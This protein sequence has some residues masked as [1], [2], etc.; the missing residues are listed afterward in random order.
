M[1]LKNLLHKICGAGCVALVAS[2]LVPAGAKAQTAYV[3]YGT[4]AAGSTVY[5]EVYEYDYVTDKP[6]FPGGEEKMIKFINRTRVYPEKAYRHGV[7]GRVMCSFIVMPDGAVSN[8]KVL[9]GVEHSLNCEAKRVIN[10]M[11]AW[12]PGRMNG[13]PVPV[14]V[15]YPITFRR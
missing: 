5:L 8:V 1:T 3:N 4:N 9:R 13:R 7:Q 12:K 15:V 14:R 2:C 6:S 10:K 11:P